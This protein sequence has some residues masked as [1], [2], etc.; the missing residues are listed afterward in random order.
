MQEFKGIIKQQSSNYISDTALLDSKNQCIITD[1]LIFEINKHT[2]NI[3]YRSNNIFI[4]GSVFVF[5]ENALKEKYQIKSI[6]LGDTI[7]QLY[8]KLGEDFISELKGE[9]SFVLVD[10]D[11]ETTLF[12]RD[13]LGIIPFYYSI[14]E[15]SIIFSNRFELVQR[16]LK[17]KFT[18]NIEWIMFYLAKKMID[19]EQTIFNEIVRLLPGHYLQIKGKEK[20]YIH[21]W[22]PTKIK[23]NLQMDF[24]YAKKELNNKLIQAVEKRLDTEKITGIELSGGIDSSSLTAFVNEQYSKKEKIKIYSNVLSSLSKEVAPDAY[25]EWNKASAVTK[26]LNLSANHFPISSSPLNSIQSIDHM[27]DVHGFPTIHHFTGM[28]LG[29]YEQAFQDQVAQL[30]CGFGGDEVVSETAKTRYFT[31]LYREK[32]AFAVF[33]AYKSLKISYYQALKNTYNTFCFVSKQVEEKRKD[34][35]H[36]NLKANFLIHDELIDSYSFEKKYDELAFYPLY[37]TLSDRTMYHLAK[38]GLVERLETGYSLTNNL[39]MRYLF[40]LFDV[41]LIEFYLTIPEEIRGKQLKTR[42]LFREVIKSYLPESIVNQAKPSN[43]YSVPFMVGVIKSELKELVEYCQQIPK[44]S[45]IYQFIDHSK[46]DCYIHNLDYNE[47]YNRKYHILMN[48][49][50]LHRFFQKHNI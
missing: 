48:V 34:R 22:N 19:K 50:M 28:Q 42:H 21:Y 5:N 36:S 12:V 35:I 16:A 8:Q 38:S 47:L 11:T 18:L 3:L 26:H 31:N 14:N 25:D 17:N 4:V 45:T 44:E 32:G 20:R 43:S 33:K 23:E 30:V 1:T 13:P 41:D 39:N 24:Q 37:Q 7:T 2:T 29:I 40:P 10:V 46:L 15:E 49:I 27:L 6:S 9:F